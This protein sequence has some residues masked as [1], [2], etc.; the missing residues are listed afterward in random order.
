MTIRRSLLFAMTALVVM[1]GLAFA[2]AYYFLG[3]VYTVE[4]ISQIVI[5]DAINQTKIRLGHLF[6]NVDRTLVAGRDYVESGKVDLKEPE[7]L[8]RVFMPVLRRFPQISSM[9][10]ADMDGRE[11][12]LLRQGEGWLN[13]LTN[14][15]QWGGRTQ[16]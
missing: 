5:A 11:Y 6:Q 1:V 15:P 7:Q 14:R 13:R 16:W 12:M 2:G 4:K 8:N 9:H 3:S 10:I